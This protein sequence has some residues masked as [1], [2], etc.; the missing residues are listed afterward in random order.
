MPLSTL[1]STFDTEWVGA[2]NHAAPTFF[3]GFADETI[4]NRLMLAMLRKKGRISLGAKS[5]MCI[6]DIKFAQ[7]PITAYGDGGEMVYS[8]SDLY[9]Q[10]ALNWR[11]YT[12]S[13]VMTEKEFLMYQGP[14]QILD[15]Y[16][17]IVPGLM[18]AMT[19]NFGQEL[20]LDGNDPARPNS[21]H[22]LESFLGATGGTVAGDLIALPSD[23]YA[24]LSTALASEGG[25]WSNNLG[26]GKRPHLD[27]DTDWPHGRG[28]TQ[29]DFNS[30]KLINWSSSR[31]GTGQTDW[32]SNCERVMRQTTIWLTN[33]GGKNGRPTMYALSNELYSGYLNHQ[34]AKGRVIYPHKESQDLGFED[35][36]NQEGVSIHYDYEVP[37]QTGYGMNMSQMELASLDN[38]LFGY[39][40]PGFDWSHK[41]WLFYVG[42]WGNA[43]Y[44]AKHFAKLYPYA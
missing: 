7:Q 25:S 21:I 28:T 9:R 42:F 15:R 14:T 18:E 19:D 24:G 36:V 30:P 32:E 26:A 38:V 31:W 16:G 41:G 2:F 1:I 40:G 29:Y 13:D 34:A 43:R 12:G 10:A 11:G 5:P 39:R 8:R 23:S 37:A 3:R 6:W 33:T 4:R 27:H 20:I 44:R 22:G 35:T 17:L